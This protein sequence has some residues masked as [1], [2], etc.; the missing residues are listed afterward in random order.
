VDYR[1]VNRNTKR[2]RTPLPL[3]DRI[4]SA[5]GRARY[6]GKIDMTNSFFQTKMH[7]DDIEKT[8]MRT[9]WGLYEWVVMPMGLCNA[10]ATHQRRI[11]NALGDLNGTICWAYLDDII[12]WSDTLEQHQKRVR[13]VLKA[14]RTASLYCS[15]KKTL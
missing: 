13:Q 1:R 8:A 4:L 5:A 9:P 14:L 12:I 6:W 2:D 15:P 7:P 10:P 11:N 3:P